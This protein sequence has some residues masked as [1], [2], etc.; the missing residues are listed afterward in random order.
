[1]VLK[2]V[3]VMPWYR[4]ETGNPRVSLSNTLLLRHMLKGDAYSRLLKSLIRGDYLV[5]GYLHDMSKDIVTT[6]IPY[7]NYLINVRTLRILWATAVASFT[8]TALPTCLRCS[9]RFPQNV[10][11][12]GK[13]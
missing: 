7:R 11:S 10:I 8:G 3:I 4:V 2:S 1:M 9:E 6:Y 5:L 13:D 12:L